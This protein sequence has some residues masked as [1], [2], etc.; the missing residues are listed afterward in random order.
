MRTVSNFMF[1][2]TRVGV[3]TVKKKVLYLFSNSDEVDD[4]ADQ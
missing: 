3:R 1:S 4:P 2:N